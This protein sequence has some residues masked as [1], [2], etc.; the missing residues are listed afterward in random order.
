M[1]VAEA[2]DLATFAAARDGCKGAEIK[3]AFGVRRTRKSGRGRAKLSYG[4]QV[5]ERVGC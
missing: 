4:W 1:G 3:V 2:D 5:R